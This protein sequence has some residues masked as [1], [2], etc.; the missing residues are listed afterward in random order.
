[1]RR[2][3][4]TDY[5]EGEGDLW[6]RLQRVGSTV[7]GSPAGEEIYW[8]ITEVMNLPNGCL[9]RTR[10]MTDRDTATTLVFVPDVVA[11]CQDRGYDEDYKIVSAETAE[12]MAKNKKSPPREATA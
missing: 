5:Y 2:V 11:V 8:F 9:I 3:E 10:D 1:M 4:T 12:Q 6:K 7:K